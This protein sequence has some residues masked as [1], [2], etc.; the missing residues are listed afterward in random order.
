MQLWDSRTDLEQFNEKYF[1]P[2]VARLGQRAFP[3]PP[4]VHD[5]DTVTTWVAHERLE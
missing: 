3:R 2:A 5:V 4:V 1:R